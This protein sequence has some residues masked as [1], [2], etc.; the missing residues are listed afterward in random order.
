LVVVPLFTCLG[1][2]VCIFFPGVCSV[3]YGS[4]LLM[5]E[6]TLTIIGVEPA[7][8]EFAIGLSDCLRSRMPAL[9]EAVR[10]EVYRRIPASL[11]RPSAEPIADAR[12]EQIHS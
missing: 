7:K 10:G 3:F 6:V 9:L 2:D 8:V 5:Y 12:D 4:L 1:L 11:G